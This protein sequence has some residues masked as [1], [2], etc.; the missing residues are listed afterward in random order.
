M[1]YDASG[2]PG[3]YDYTEDPADVERCIRLRD[4]ALAHAVPLEKFRDQIN[5]E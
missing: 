5:M 4:V 1:H 2:K 3:E